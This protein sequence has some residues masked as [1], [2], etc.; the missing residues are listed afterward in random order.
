MRHYPPL[1]STVLLGTSRRK[2]QQKF[3]LP[4]FCSSLL[5]KG[6]QAHAR[7]RSWKLEFN[8]LILFSLVFVCTP[9]FGLFCSCL[10]IIANFL[11]ICKRFL[12][13]PRDLHPDLPAVTFCR[14]LHL[15]SALSPA[16]L[17]TS[18][19]Q[20][21]PLSLNTPVCH[22]S[23]IVKIRKKVALIQYLI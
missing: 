15:L 5:T 16:R 8:N 18:W 14:Q 7:D 13:L 4:Q 1:P 21:T 20:H 23:M 3:N 6:E 9:R 11:E 17:R 10:E 2:S 12:R 19:R 22:L